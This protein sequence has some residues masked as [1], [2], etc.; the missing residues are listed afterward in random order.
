MS[1]PR[2]GGQEE[3]EEEEEM[4]METETE[5]E[6]EEEAFCATERIARSS[7]DEIEKRSPPSPRRRR[8]VCFAEKALCSVF[9]RK[10]LVFFFLF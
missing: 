7:S 3:E 5:M 1:G 8:S 9:S 2:L 10:L 4:E 6:M